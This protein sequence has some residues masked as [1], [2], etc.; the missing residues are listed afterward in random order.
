MP[1]NNLAFAEKF[2]GELDKLFVQGPVTGFFADNVLRSKFVGAKT[3]LIPEMDMSALGDYNRD[4]GFTMGSVAVSNQPYTLAMDRARSFQLDRE[5][6]DETGIANLAGQV[7]SEFVRTK[8]VPEV[9]AYVL[10]KLGGLAATKGQTVTGDHTTEVIKMFNDACLKVQNEAGFDE[11][12]VCFVNPTVWAA[13]QNT[14]EL[15]RQLVIND[16]KK[17]DLALKV[18]SINGIAI[19]PVADARMKTAYEFLDGVTE[20]ETDGGFK[21]A[22]G[23]KSIGMLVM[24]K[25]A[26]SLVR[27]SEKIRTFS[28]D[29]NQAADAYKFDYRTYYDVIVKNSLTKS[30]YAYVY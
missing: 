23:A 11:P 4:T 26:A 13:I 25:K 3:V 2:T 8:V 21:P 15:N 18:K 5:D 27:K 20:G 19:L 24:P 17:G 14:P 9:D 7:M 29:Q 12:L 6:E 10:S 16:F 30:I 22:D 1:I 28:P